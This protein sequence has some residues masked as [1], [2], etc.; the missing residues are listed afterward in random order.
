MSNDL[1]QDIQTL[2]FL[3]KPKA[4]A[5]LKTLIGEVFSLDVVA[6]ELRPLA[7]SLNSFNG[8]VTLADN[9]RLFFKTHTE[10]DSVVGE[11]YNSAVLAEAGY[12]VIRPVMSSTESGKQLLIYEVINDPSVFDVAWQ[13]ECGQSSEAEGLSAAQHAADDELRQFYF[14]RLAIQPAEQAAQAG[15]HQLFY[16]RLTGGRLVKFY[17]SLPG[18]QGEDVSIQLPGTTMPMSAVRRK[19]WV[20]NGQRYEVTLDNLIQNAIEDLNPAQ[21]GP[22]VIGHGDAHNGNVFYNQESR[23]LTYFDPAFAGRHDPLLDLTKPL[24]HNVFAMWMYFPQEKA[25]ALNISWDQQGD[26]WIVDHNYNL[27]PIRE[28]FLT[29]KTDRVLVPL[30]SELVRRG[31]LRSDWRRFLKSALFCCPFLTMNLAD[32]NKF[33]PEISLLGLSMAV[34]MGADSMDKRSRIDQLFDQVETGLGQ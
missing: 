27:H 23:S 4:E 17:G 3:D 10:P 26:T 15:V 5:M 1:L 14:N 29:S 8:F 28:M 13:I 30:L 12:P 24:F 6:V 20:I 9:R 19:Q 18:Q 11:Y 33:P 32:A 22:S 2:Q 34:E 7:V 31:W 25:Q 21:E 16:H